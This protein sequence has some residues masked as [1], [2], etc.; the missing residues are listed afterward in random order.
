MDTE[1]QTIGLIGTGIMGGH[2]GRRLSSAGFPLLVHSR[3]REKAGPLL[4]AGARWRDGPGELAAEAEVVLTV[5]G[6]PADVEAVL[7]APGGAL[8]RARP[9]TVF[10]D[11]STSSPVLARTV[12]AAAAERGLNALDAPMTGGEAGAREGRLTFMVGGDRAA[13]ERVRP[14]LEVLGARIAYQGP[15]GSGQRAKLINQAMVAVTLLGV[16]EGLALADRT[17]HDAAA[18]FDAIG[19]GTASG[20]ILNAHGRRMLARDFAPGFYVRHLLKDVELAL[21]AAREEGLT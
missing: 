15:A 17:G 1:R 18:L 8:E 4:A 16:A 5:V 19:S 21:D 13:L 20:F 9:G 14:V 2:M 10:V 3:T 11:C 7:L 6:G 12:A